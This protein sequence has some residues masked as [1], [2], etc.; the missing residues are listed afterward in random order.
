MKIFLATD[1]AGFALKETVRQMLAAQGREVEDLGAFSLDP[2]DDYTDTIPFAARAVA[3]APKLHKAIVFGMSGQGEAMV[4]NRFKG[5]RAAVYTGGG[6]QV[7]L[8]SREHNDANVLSIGAKFV[9]EDEAKRIITLW[10]DT[11]FS[12][13]E[14]H[15]RRVQALDFIT[16]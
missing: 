8:L 1:H 5:V 7:V 15:I 4:C 12:G 6:D 10:L 13:E 11:P 16:Q 14:R 9:G 3:D 2:K